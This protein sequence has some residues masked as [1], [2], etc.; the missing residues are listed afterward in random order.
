MRIRNWF[1]FFGLGV[2]HERPTKV[3][4]GVH[5]ETHATVVFDLANY[6]EST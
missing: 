5:G 3:D 6:G 2:R 4:L 1:G